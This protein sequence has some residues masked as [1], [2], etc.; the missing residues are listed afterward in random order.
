MTLSTKFLIVPS[1][2]WGSILFISACSGDANLNPE[3]TLEISSSHNEHSYSSGLDT[4]LDKSSVEALSQSVSIDDTESHAS[5]PMSSDTTESETTASS[6]QDTSESNNSSE[7]T[8]SQDSATRSSN[9]STQSSSTAQSLSS[10]SEPTA[11]LTSDPG[12]EPWVLVASQDV[13]RECGL[14]PDL[15]AAADIQIARSYAVVRFGKLCHEYYPNGEPTVDEL[16]HVYSAS[17]TLAAVTIGTVAYETK[18]IT[19]DGRKT[20]P[21]SEL[22]RVDHWLD[23]KDISY[24]SNAYVEH[25][26]AM[27]AYNDDLS[28]GA[29][30]FSYDA[31]GSRE[32]QT[33]ATIMGTAIAQ[34]AERLG[35]S[36][37]EFTE[38]YIFKPLGMHHSKWNNSWGSNYPPMAYGWNTTVR[39]MAR[40]GLLIIHEGVWNGQRILD[41]S[42]IYKMTHPAF[43][44]AQKSYGYLTWL[45]ASCAPSP[46]H[47]SYPH[48]LSEA[49]DCG[50]FWGCDQEYD[51]GVWSA[52][53]MYGQIIMGH[54][55]LDLVLVVKD[56]DPN[57]GSDLWE[58]VRPALV[59]H[60][61][62][63]NGDESAFC[64]EYS[65][66][67][68]APN[69]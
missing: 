39:D 26:L 11:L 12:T 2:L 48:G 15:L 65:A 32:I 19:T 59:S 33:L 20:G 43:E 21:L 55:G 23:A 40:L 8:S 36:V 56:Y 60:D 38:N 18:D 46:I 31:D 17:K 27:V 69:L 50:S 57:D 53:G 13:A 14:D 24:N 37:K 3:S 22:D 5:T 49:T 7:E 68:Y 34:D 41:E 61:S 30:S 1:V 67:R 58:A 63:Y 35:S 29:K 54:K 16:T 66:G 44:D 28:H 4:A 52:I 62:E 47:T 42:W 51:V 45:G 9:T 6:S 64:D 25:L 10:S